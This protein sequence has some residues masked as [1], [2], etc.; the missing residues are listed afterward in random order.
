LYY[1]SHIYKNVARYRHILIKHTQMTARTPSNDSTL[2]KIYFDFATKTPEGKVQCKKCAV[3]CKD[4]SGHGN[5]ASH[6]KQKHSEWKEILDE[7]L[8]GATRNGGRPMDNFVTVTRVVSDEAKDMSAWI[9]WIVFSDLPIIMVENEQFRK[10]SHLR[11]T[12]YKTVSKHM[13]K[14]LEIIR[15]NI[16]RTLP[17][18][19]GL[20]FDGTL[21]LYNVYFC[22]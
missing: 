7:H 17:K 10:N 13:A 11:A 12:T 20:L 9:E 15:L 5:L 14:L 8:L 22:K 19:F 1:Y 6:V 3:F 4:N 18:T 16:K 21:L 2:A